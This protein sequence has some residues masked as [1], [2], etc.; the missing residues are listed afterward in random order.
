[1]QNQQSPGPRLSTILK[2]GLGAGA[3]AAGYH[4]LKTAFEQAGGELMIHRTAGLASDIAKGHLANRIQEL[5]NQS[6][7]NSQDID[8]LAKRIGNLDK[9]LSSQIQ[10]LHQK[11]PTSSGVSRT[12]AFGYGY[13]GAT[14]AT[15]GAATVALQA[16]NTIHFRVAL[17][18]LQRMGYIKL[19][20]KSEVILRAPT[21]KRIQ[22][23]V[24]GMDYF[25]INPLTK[26]SRTFNFDK[27]LDN[28]IDDNELAKKILQ[29]MRELP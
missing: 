29:Q 12:E 26:A 23:R 10:D 24:L 13:L 9:N 3:L 4:G 27:R 20:S 22:Y 1:M 7:I 18:I 2:Y 15:L 25:L 21:P 14:A 16:R 11:I 17:N 8:T 19:V 6:K 5:G 28:P